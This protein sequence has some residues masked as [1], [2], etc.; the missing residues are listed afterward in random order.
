MDLS[1]VLNI[2]ASYSEDLGLT[3]PD[4]YMLLF[5]TN[6]IYHELDITQTA[7]NVFSKGKSN[8][9]LTQ[10]IMA[11]IIFEEG[12]AELRK[13]IK[14]K[15]L[16]RVG[17]HEAIYK[18]LCD[19]ISADEF[20]SN[21]TKQS[22]ISCCDP[23]D[24]DQLAHFITLCIICGNY[25]TIQQKSK[26]PKILDEYGVNLRKLATVSASFYEE[27]VLWECSK[28]DF[29]ASRR[30]GG[31]F[32]SLNIIQAILPKGYVSEP[33]FPARYREKD[34]T[35]NTVIDICKSSTENISIVGEGGIGKTTFLHQLMSEE[36]FCKNGKEK[37]YKSGCSVPFFIEL[38]RCP[39]QIKE[40][41]N[42]SLGKTN[43]I[44]RYIGQLFENHKSIDSVEQNTLDM[45]E[46]EFQRIPENGAPRY[47]L[48]LD[49]FNE[50]KSN[51]GLSIRT[52][53][54]NEISVLN[55]YPN[56]RIITTSRET[57][58]AYYAADFK[59]VQLIGLEDDD[60]RSYFVASCISEVL[61]G[62]YTSTLPA[63]VPPQPRHRPYLLSG[64]SQDA[65]FRSNHHSYPNL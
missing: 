14:T 17:C 26:Q 20:L 5:E 9:A 38:N 65:L 25:N 62:L 56:I 6:G 47:L 10:K 43:F 19:Q 8:R 3:N 2:M 33:S 36:F 27:Q 4:L 59:N 16:S 46:K 18:D 60:I 1:S 54:S 12:D 61:I 55:T 30:E 37:K 45:I 32:A 35:I 53:L 58:A 49:G 11:N 48:L 22:L 57:Q 44:T 28:R 21:T 34:G 63:S 52:L 64:R 15:W 23:S 29:L 39:E 13:R 51:E 40:W 41:H 7:K 31:R 24:E 50:V 42:E